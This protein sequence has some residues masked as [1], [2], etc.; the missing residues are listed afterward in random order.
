MSIRDTL[1]FIILAAVFATHFICLY[2]A[3]SMFFP[4]ISVKN[5][6][7]RILVEVMLGAWLLLMFID[8][9]YRPRFSWI[10]GGAGAFLLVIA[11]ADAFGVNP[12]RSFWSNYERM[13]GLIAHVHLFLYFLIAGTV[14][15]A[16]KLWLWFWRTS[17]GVSLI[18][19]LYAF[20][21]LAGKADIHQGATRLDASF[22]NA[23][24]LA[25]Y[26]LFHIFLA[27]FLYARE[28]GRNA[29]RW[30]YLVVG[31]V[32]FLILYFT[33][34]RGAL[35]GVIGGAF[36]TFLLVALLDKERPQLRKY[37]LGGVI[38]LVVLVGAF[39]MFRDASWIKNNP[40][41]SRMASI[42]LS[43]PTTQAR[44]LIWKM[45]WEGFK[46]RP[47][48]GWGQENFLYVFSKH[49]DPKM[50]NQEPW[51]D[52]SHNVFFDWLIAGGA[53]GLLTYLSLFGA[54]L[55]YL[56]FSR[57]IH[58]SILERSIFTGMLAGYFVHNIF[59]FDNLTSYIVFF[60]F[61]AYLHSQVTS[62]KGGEAAPAQHKKGE[63]LETND[64]AVARVIVLALTPV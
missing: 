5:F 39:I 31:V 36:L 3:N 15:H 17:L 64:M 48:L 50:W 34:T 46:E 44:F 40:T 13:E 28:G 58:L 45:S 23:T 26:A 51:F 33:Q 1:R 37:A 54:A 60:G 8:S 59:V 7:F 47:I 10:L 16:E 19:A 14:L 24:Y 18:V 21:Q 32:N 6:L 57:K 9:T 41:L 35:L 62:G 4:F 27:A 30:I 53:L 29:Y 55:Y 63:Q 22:G 11:A 25:V 49:Y 56:W 12:W 38:A 42:S 43:D 2:V 20:S 61:L 52:R